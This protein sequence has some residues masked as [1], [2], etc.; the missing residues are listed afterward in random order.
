MTESDTWLLYLEPEECDALLAQADLGRLGVIQDGRPLVF[1][2]CHVYTGGVLAFPTNVGTKLHAA[3]SWPYVSFEV[4]GIEDDGLTG[5]S[6]MVAGRAELVD[7]AEDVAAY[8]ALRDVPWRTSPS[9]RWVRV[10]PSEIS[11]RRILGQ[12]PIRRPAP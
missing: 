3:L 4:D 11:G 9:L 8:T 12:R 7:A 10:V 5:W 1:P 6:V 2:V